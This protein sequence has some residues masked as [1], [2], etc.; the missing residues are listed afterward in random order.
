MLFAVSVAQA[1]TVYRW[2]D[3]GGVLCFTDD[4]KR[5][6]AVYQDK[7]E[8]FELGALADYSR[9]T[10]ILNVFPPPLEGLREKAAKEN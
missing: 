10:K 3:D 7:A 9:Y 1:G 5:V 6:P 4:E 8:V 2:V